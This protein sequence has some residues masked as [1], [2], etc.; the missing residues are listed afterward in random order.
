MVLRRCPTTP[1]LSYLNRIGAP[2]PPRQ[3]L[4]KAVQGLNLGAAEEGGLAPED[5][6]AYV[7]DLAVITASEDLAAANEENRE[8]LQL[9]LDHQR[10]RAQKCHTVVQATVVAEEE[11]RKAEREVTRAAVVAAREAAKAAKR[12][13]RKEAAK[14]A[15][16]PAREAKAEKERANQAKK[17]AAREARNIAREER[18]AAKEASR[19]KRKQAAVKA[20]RAAKEKRCDNSPIFLPSFPHV[21]SPFYAVSRGWRI[22]WSPP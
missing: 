18:K 7:A 17:E 4:A 8:R 9:H 5:H 21:C 3:A 1:S 2:I 20:A 13:S 12:A 16:R 19:K 11:Q 14:E 15:K 6:A 10:R 22:Q